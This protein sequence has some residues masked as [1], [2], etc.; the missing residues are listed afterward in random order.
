MFAEEVLRSDAALA[1]HVVRL[2]RGAPRAP[3]ESRAAAGAHGCGHGYRSRPG[4]RARRYT[5]SRFDL[6]AGFGRVVWGRLDEVQP[7][8]VVNPLD[9]SRFFFEGRSEA[10][11][12]VGLIRARAF[13]S[14]RRHDRGRLRAVLPARAVRSARRADVA[15][16]HRGRDACAAGSG[17]RSRRREPPATFGNAQG[18]AR[19]SATTG[20]VDWSVSAYRGFEPFGFGD[21]AVRRRSR[22]DRHRVPAL[23]DDRRRL[24][25]RPRPVGPAR[26]GGGV[27]GRQLPGVRAPERGRAAARSTRA[28]AL[29]RKAGDYRISGSVLVHHESYD[30][31]ILREDGLQRARSEVS[32]ILS[33]DRSFAA[34]R[35]QVRDLRRVQRHRELG[36][37][38]GDRDGEA[39]RQ[40][41]ARGIGRLVRRRGR[42]RDRPVR[43]QRLR[44]RE[45]EVLLLK[46]ESSNVLSSTF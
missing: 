34:E 2:C 44:L 29:D 16:Q 40:C 19:F 41:L 30:E 27:R 5:T 7:T 45:G 21:F 3:R 37:P 13:L 33:A 17:R 26:R 23:H 4:R 35:Y 15:V 25:D 42:N 18:G 38:A 36:V 1:L 11:L 9:V 6:L 28:P 46:F 12:P 10:R 43:R 20:R 8:D 24:R 39:P 31:P 32:L 14:E 22:S